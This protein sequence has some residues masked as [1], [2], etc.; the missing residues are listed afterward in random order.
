MTAKGAQKQNA[1][2]LEHLLAHKN[3]AQNPPLF[4]KK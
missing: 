3:T 2:V 1:G 4:Y